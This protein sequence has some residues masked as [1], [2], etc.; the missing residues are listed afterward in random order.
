MMADPLTE[1]LLEV[2][3]EAGAEGGEAG[4]GRAL[5]KII[6][7]LER[8]QLSTASQLRTV[9]QFA[10]ECPALSV[11][12]IYKLIERGER[13]GLAKSKAIV[14]IGGRVFI[15]RTRFDRWLEGKIRC[16]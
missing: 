9:R 6:E 1:S 8:L 11:R 10:E 2:A 16:G 15:H 14:R 5:E 4:A 12:A 3:R 13:N 7:R